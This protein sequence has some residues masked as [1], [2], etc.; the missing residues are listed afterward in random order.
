M[1]DIDE[2]EH[3]DWVLKNWGNDILLQRRGRDGEYT[4]T[5]ERHTVRISV[6]TSMTLFRGLVYRTEGETVDAGWTFYFRHDA[7]PRVSDRIYE[8]ERRHTDVEIGKQTVY[9]ITDSYPVKGRSGYIAF[10]A[11]RAQR[12][13]PT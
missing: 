12:R 4:N 5:F 10:Y 6:A 11:V 9:D 8:Y 1:A 3:F 2:R 13:R 7:D